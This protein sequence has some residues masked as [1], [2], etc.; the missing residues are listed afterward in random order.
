MATPL[1]RYAWSVLSYNVL[2]ILW[3]AYVRATGSGAGCGAH[4]PL[5]NGEVI[6]RTTTVEMAIEFSHRASS[7][8]ALLAVIVLLFWVRRSC[9]AGHRARLGAASSLVFILTEAG[10]GA[11]LVLFRLV[12]GDE[13]LARVLVMPLHLANTLV[14]LACLT[15]TAHW[16]SGGAPVSLRGRGR[17]A[18]IVVGALV[19]LAGVGTT[20]AVAAIGD[21]LYPA[22]SLV[23]GIRRDWSPTASLAIRLRILHPTLAVAAGVFLMFGLMA[24]VRVPPG[25]ERGQRAKHALI[26]LIVA[27]VLFGF[28]N[29]WMLAP[30]WMQLVHLLLAD[31]MWIALV[32]TGAAVL[33]G[34][35]DP[36]RPA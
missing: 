28:A 4:W 32:L 17:T 36:V 27:Q 21:T 15:L 12:A 23:D 7:G 34:P 10:L 19:A 20:G 33:A 25:D 16:V 1:A 14:L 35:E 26:G 3:G 13:S 6:P 18:A 5:C 24:R 11:G 31:L 30:I 9:S 29:L 2:V 8:L 22:T